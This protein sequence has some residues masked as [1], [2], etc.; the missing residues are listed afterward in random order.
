MWV[1][2]GSQQDV[3]GATAEKALAVMQGLGSHLYNSPSPARTHCQG[4]P[5]NRRGA[6]RCIISLEAE[7][8]RHGGQE[9]P[10]LRVK[11]EGLGLALLQVLGLPLGQILQLEV[12]VQPWD[13]DRPLHSMPL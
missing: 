8:R 11:L 6:H 12:P 5:G 7:G 4:R 9:G 3:T 1:S 13:D 2:S 10:R